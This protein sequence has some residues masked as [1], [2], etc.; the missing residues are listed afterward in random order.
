MTYQTPITIRMALDS[1]WKND[2]VLP[3]IQREFVWRPDQ[4]TRLFDSLM[5]S[6]PIGSF[7]FWQIEKEI[8]ERFRFFGFVCDYHQRN[9]PHCPPLGKA[10][11][12]RITAVLDGQQRLTALNIGLKGSMA[13]KEPNKWWNN[14]NAFPTKRLYLDLGH[15]PNLDEEGQAYRLEFLTETRAKTPREAELWFEVPLVFGMAT[16]YDVI[17]YMAGRNLGSNEAAVSILSR[18]HAVVHLDPVV[19]FYEEK[20]QD[21]EKVLNIFIRTNSGGTVLSYSDLL[22]SIATAQWK[23]RDARSEVHNLVDELNDIRQGFDLSKDFVLKAGLMLADIASVGFKVENFNHTNMLSLED[24][25]DRIAETLKLTVELVGS[26]GLSRDTLRADS[27]L[28]PVAYYLH[29]SQAKQTF[30]TSSSA[31]EDRTKIKSW[32]I[33]SLIKPGVWGSG[34]DVLLSALREVLRSAPDTHFPVAELEQEM[35]A[36]GKTLEFTAEEIEDLVDISYGQKSLL[37]LMILLFPFVDTANNQFHIDHVYPR[38]QFYQRRLRN[39]F[40]RDEIEEYQSL[41]ERLANLQLL[42]GTLNQEKSGLLPSEWMTQAFKSRT[43][44]EAYVSRHLLDGTQADISGFK[45]F[46]LG[47]RQRL[48]EHLTGTL[49]G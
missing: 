14:P 34:L 12:G 22:L 32:L 45:D 25:W 43:D 23:N 1:I 27:V 9:N 46:Y 31:A 49:N 40:S 42:E 11:E 21:I 6:F 17:K 37:P 10:P 20:N 33:R 8:T 3:A 39:T 35:S 36:R 38:A 41:K 47:R 7:L 30:L 44:R 15:H 28:L 26:F 24:G 48:I 19:A 29:N 18:L 16:A 5:Q 4:I 13:V 2:F